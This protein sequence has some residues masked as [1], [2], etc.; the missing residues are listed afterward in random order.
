MYYVYLL[1]RL[2]DKFL[3]R[4]INRNLMDPLKVFRRSIW[5]GSIKL[6]HMGIIKRRI[7]VENVPGVELLG[8]I[9]GYLPVPVNSVDSTEFTGT[10]TI[11]YLN[12]EYTNQTHSLLNMLFQ[13]SH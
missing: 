6:L 1:D 10:F 12:N 3:E 11:P 13:I 9:N 8:L 2:S 5:T 7:C 4:L